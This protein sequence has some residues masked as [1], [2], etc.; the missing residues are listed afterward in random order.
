MA[1]TA[2]SIDNLLAISEVHAMA[3]QVVCMWDDLEEKLEDNAALLAA[4]DVR[5]RNARKATKVIRAVLNKSHD[6][7]EDM[8]RRFEQQRQLEIQER[9]ADD[10]L[11]LQIKEDTPGASVQ[12]TQGKKAIRP[13]VFLILPWIDV[14]QKPESKSA[15]EV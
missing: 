3:M 4:M 8:K 14:S 7:R 1:V 9:Q 5:L 11:L 10:Q 2:T 6:A 15:S 12:T 13:Q